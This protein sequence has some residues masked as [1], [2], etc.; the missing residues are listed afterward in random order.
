MTQRGV[1]VSINSDS[2]EER[3]R[4]NQ[5]AAKTMKYGGVTEEQALKLVTI[6]PALQ[7]GIDK[8]VGSIEVGK[9]ADLVLYDAHPL[10]TF[11]V[12]QQVII[13]GIV[14][15]DRAKDLEQRAVR[16]KQK[17]ALKDKEKATGTPARPTPP[18]TTP[19][20]DTTP[21]SKDQR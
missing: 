19:K 6:N 1:V 21:D 9:D 4:L 10:S 7:L 16:A 11:A 2:A 15:F 13:D 3:R 17:Q 14:Y 12:P 5:E 18:D 8:R 20:A